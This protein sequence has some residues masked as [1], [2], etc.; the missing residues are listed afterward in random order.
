MHT[1]FDVE[2]QIPTFIHITEAKVHD[3]NVMDIIPYETGAYYIFDR[4]YYDL[5]R[6]YHINK[7]S[8]YFVI[9]EKSGLNYKVIKDNDTNH[10]W[11]GILSDQLIQLTGYA[12]A[13]KYPDELR[14][15][16]FYAETLNRTF[17]Y[18]TNNV[19]ISAEQIALL[20]KY[21]WQVEL[22]FKWIKQHL[23]IKSFWGTTESAVRIQIFTAI[24]AYCMVAIVE[25]DLGLHRST[26]EVLRILSASLLDKT[27]IKEL[28]TNEI[29]DVVEDGQLTLIFF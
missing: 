7:I 5:K 24:T 27:P 18:L 9:R 21:R 23:K 13:K 8:A 4:G 26:Y 2:M 19:E 11:G 3:V 29:A 12:S 17:V 22:F 14:R 1:L 28:F 10:N 20:Y 25:H 15:V 6:L 16:V